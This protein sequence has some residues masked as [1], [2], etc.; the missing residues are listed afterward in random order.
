MARSTRKESEVLDQAHVTMFSSAFGWMAVAWKGVSLTR[1]SFGQSTPQQALA[2]LGASDHRMRGEV[3]NSHP[4]SGAARGGGGYGALAVGV[5]PRP[6][7]AY[8]ER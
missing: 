8:P 7:F 2:V 5:V 1:I 3:P 6:P 4:C